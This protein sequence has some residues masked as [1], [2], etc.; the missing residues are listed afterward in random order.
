MVRVDSEKHIDFALTSPFNVGTGRPGRV[1]RKSAKNKGN[2]VCCC[3]C[4]SAA[5]LLL[6]CWSDLCQQNRKP[7][8]YTT[9]TFATDARLHSRTHCYHRLHTA[10]YTTDYYP[11]PLTTLP[12]TTTTLIAE[13]MLLAQATPPTWT[14]S[15]TQ[16][17]THH[18]QR[19]KKKPKASQI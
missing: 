19:N 16:K 4:E 9:L 7:T 18:Q 2:P 15:I 10:L 6:L 17:T 1:A 5:T 13:T 11:S 14:T 3:F 12:I 8:L